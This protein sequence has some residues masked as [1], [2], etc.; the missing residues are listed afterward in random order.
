LVFKIFPGKE[1]RQL[2]SIL[3]EALEGGD[4]PCE[5]EVVLQEDDD[6]LLTS[7]SIRVAEDGTITQVIQLV[8]ISSFFNVRS[9]SN[10]NVLV[11]GH[12]F[13]WYS[14]THP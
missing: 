1:E 9:H 7:A 5:V 2:L 10:S 8:V 4:A 11:A 13:R 6:T 12:W 14:N 3:S